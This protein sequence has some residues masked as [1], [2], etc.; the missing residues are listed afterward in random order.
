MLF[1]FFDS[2]N[3]RGQLVP[4]VSRHFAAAVSAVYLF[5]IAGSVAVAA[6]EV[7]GG[8][9]LFLVPEFE[10]L[11]S[12]SR[13]DGVPDIGIVPFEYRFGNVGS[14]MALLTERSLAA[15]ARGRMRV[16]SPDATADALTEQRLA[17]KVKFDKRQSLRPGVL[18]GFD[19]LVLG[20]VREF[21]MTGLKAGIGPFDLPFIPDSAKASVRIDYALLDVRAGRVAFEKTVYASGA[22]SDFKVTRQSTWKATVDFLS[23]QFAGHPIGAP[24]LNAAEEIAFETASIFP[25]FGKIADVLGTSVVLD[26]ETDSPFRA[27]DIV[28]VYKEKNRTGLLGEHLWTDA[29]NVGTIVILEVRGARAICEILRGKGEI[30]T[31]MKVKA[32]PVQVA[33]TS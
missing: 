10:E 4:N 15:K 27:G 30:S 8:D 16:I 12:A 23:P 21:E 5:T 2:V 1:V 31:G 22:A 32:P 17:D 29:E 28:E 19:F 9:S 11:L 7:K 6:Q 24:S 25:L 20:K 3:T 33:K 26:F 13:E 14:G 18:E